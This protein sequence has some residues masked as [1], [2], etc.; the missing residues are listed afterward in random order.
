MT[1][2]ENQAVV[3]TYRN[4]DDAEA[5]V[6]KL[7]DSGVPMQHVSIIGRNWMHRDRAIH[8]LEI[9]AAANADRAERN[10]AAS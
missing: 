3:A 7:G 5:A 6:R 1:V 9:G 2:A 8:C 4:H 10:T